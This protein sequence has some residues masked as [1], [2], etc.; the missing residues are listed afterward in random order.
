[1]FN[2]FTSIESLANVSKTVG[3]YFLPP[4]VQY[5]A[6]IKLHGTNAAITIN[7]NGDVFAQSRSRVITLGDDN[8][9][10]AAYVETVKHV[11]KNP[12]KDQV[13]TYHGEWA[14]KGI[15]QKDAV[16]QLGRKYFFIFAVQIGNTMIVDPQAI[17]ALLPTDCIET[18]N[19]IVLPSYGT[20]SVDFSSRDSLSF[21]ADKLNEEVE[22]IAE[23]DPFISD[24]FGVEGPGEGLVLAPHKPDG[25][26]RETYSAYVFK[27][28][29]EAHRV[30]K[31]DKAVKI[32]AETPDD[33]LAFVEM[34]VTGARCEQGLMEVCEG[35]P[36]IRM[37]SKFLAWVGGD[38]KKE[39]TLELESMGLEWKNVSAHVNKAAAKWFVETCNKVG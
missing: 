2:K 20:Y 1:M 12:T 33:I 34:F 5:I 37:T 6:K 8:A 11:W 24:L 4:K 28:K 7:E 25:V 3:R 36:D 31:S 35:I 21:F 16:T 23:V 18:D 38:V 13:I 26:D 30:K 9:G 17:E 10:F 15:Q 27:A 19:V 14:G 32:S 29:T 39:S 22:K